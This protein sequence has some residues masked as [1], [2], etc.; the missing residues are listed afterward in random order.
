ML[1]GPA[2][3]GLYSFELL[4]CHDFPGLKIEIINSKTFLVFHDL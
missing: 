1:L 3:Q 4:K 2:T